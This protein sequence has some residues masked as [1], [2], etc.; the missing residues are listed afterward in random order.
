MR[1]AFFAILLSAVLILCCSCGAHTAEP[2]EPS[3]AVSTQAEPVTESAEPEQAEVPAIDELD[4]ELYPYYALLSEDARTVFREVAACIERGDDEVIPSVRIYGSEMDRISLFIGYDLPQ[5]FWYSGGL[6]YTYNSDNEV[7][8]VRPQ[9]NDLVD[10]REENRAAVEAVAADL[11][12]QTADMDEAQT[13]RFFHD[14]LCEHVAYERGSYD[15]NLYS[16]LVEGQTVCA[17]YTHALQYLLTRSGIPCY[18][19]TGQ[20]Y[21]RETGTWESHGWNLVRLGGSFYAVDVTWDDDY[22]EADKY[23]SA[24]CYQ[25]YNRTD[26]ELSESHVRDDYGGLL[27]ACDGTEASF[28]ALYGITIQQ[29]LVTDLNCSYGETV[30]SMEEYYDLCYAAI[31]SHG[32]GACTVSFVTGDPAVAETINSSSFDGE[33]DGFVK[34]CASRLGLNGWSYSRSGQHWDLGGDCYYYEMTL[35]LTA[36]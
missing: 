2:R 7:T 1:R 36:A 12:A 10:A 31:T 17:G 27:P 16:A 3:A 18:F 6:T 30:D 26:D 14:W 4:P 29:Q 8:A 5:L 34:S 25:Y 35:S 20:A 23:P 19:C 24:V 13:E 21:N 9:Y 28:E 15:Q 22:L 33:S 32:T 11:L